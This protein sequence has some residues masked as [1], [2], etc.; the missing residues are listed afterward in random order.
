M[1][2]IVEHALSQRE[3]RPGHMQVTWSITFV[4]NETR[5]GKIGMLGE[6]NY[7]LEKGDRVYFFNSDKVVY[8]HPLD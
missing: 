2:D 3:D 4:N 8:M 5:S 1:S 7:A 6:G